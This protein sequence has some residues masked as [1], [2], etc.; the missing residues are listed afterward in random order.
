MSLWQNAEWC[1]CVIYCFSYLLSETL[2]RAISSAL[3]AYKWLPCF[4]I[5]SK[6]SP[7]CVNSFAEMFCANERKHFLL[8]IAC[9]L[10]NTKQY[11][12]YHLHG[13]L[14]V[15]YPWISTPVNVSFCRWLSFKSMSYKPPHPGGIVSQETAIWGFPSLPTRRS[16]LRIGG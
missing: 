5:T 7:K 15:P 12:T 6:T 10:S 13:K 1:S 14:Q 8:G 11:K 3:H 9:F 2:M 4:V 16:W